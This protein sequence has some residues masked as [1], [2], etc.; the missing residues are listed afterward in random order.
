M[1]TV[2][3]MPFLAILEP[4]YSNINLHYYAG[5]LFKIWQLLSR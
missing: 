1:C 4:F 2:I 3:C 5:K